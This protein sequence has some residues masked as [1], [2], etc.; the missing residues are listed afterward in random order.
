MWLC[1]C[2]LPALW[3]VCDFDVLLQAGNEQ[4]LSQNSNSIWSTSSLFM[5]AALQVPGLAQQQ[6][7]S[8][9]MPDC[10]RFSGLPS[11]AAMMLPDCP[12]DP[13]ACILQHQPACES[14]AAKV[15]SELVLHCLRNHGCFAPNRMRRRLCVTQ[16]A[17]QDSQKKGTGTCHPDESAASILMSLKGS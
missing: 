6:L 13:P 11:A 3:D 17:V 4:A 5:P 9:G 8:E 16:S 12:N 15:C 7:A 1:S 14:P 10:N 2:L